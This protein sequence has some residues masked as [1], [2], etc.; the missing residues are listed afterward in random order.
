M[1]LP[2]MNGSVSWTPTA[3]QIDGLP[4]AQWGWAPVLK[5]ENAIELYDMLDP[6][7]PTPEPED[8]S[9]EVQLMWDESALYLLVTITDD[10]P[11]APYTGTW[12]REDTVELY[13]DLDLSGSGGDGTYDGVNDWEIGF[14]ALADP[15]GIVTGPNSVDNTAG[16]RAM[17]RLTANG[18]QLEAALPWDTLGLEGSPSAGMEIGLDVHVVDNDNQLG[19]REHKLA[20]HGTVDEAWRDTRRL[21][22]VVMIDVVPD[23]V[24]DPVPDPL[25]SGGLSV[26]FERLARIPNSPATGNAPRLNMLKEVPDGSGRL[27]VIDQLGYLYVVLPDNSVE[28]YLNFREELSDNFIYDGGQTGSTSFAFHPEF[29]ANGKFYVVTSVERSTGDPDFVAKRPID[30]TLDGSDPRSPGFHDILLELTAAD[31]SAS[32]FS[33][34]HREILRVEQPYGDHNLGEVA[35]N[36]NAAPGD[37]DYGL[38]YL[39]VADGGNR[40]PIDDADPENNGQDYSTIL[41][42]IIRIDP[43]GTNGR[44]GQY[45]IPEDNPF[46]ASTGGPL[47]EIWSYGHRNPHRINWDTRGDKALYAYE[48]GQGTF[49]EIN[50][51][52][53]GG[54]YG[55]GNR[56]GTSLLLEA[57]E[58]SPYPVP[59]Q[60][61]EGTYQYPVFQYDHPGTLS[62]AIAGGAVYRGSRIPSLYG[63]LIFADFTTGSR[64][65]FY[66]NLLDTFDLPYASAARY[67]VLGITSES[68]SPVDIAAALLGTGGGTRTDA[69]I[70]Q[71][72]SGEVYFTNKRN[73]W[74]HRMLPGPDEHGIPWPEAFPEAIEVAPWIIEAASLGYLHYESW[75]WLYSYAIGWFWIP[76]AEATAD[77]SGLWIYVPR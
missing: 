47:P 57:D 23:A 49:E 10:A 28:L 46:A 64:G 32:A 8:L 11:Q 68:G 45:G 16:F 15:V 74:I 54:N 30:P 35:T 24:A 9:A 14:H 72:L 29:A 38:L 33:G 6:Q 44:N 2:W 26:T 75:P 66:G 27:F 69:R 73:G 61:P 22:A 31:P 53:P 12:F 34:T 7:D 42:S 41:G 76:D 48:I 19:L 5:L 77:S 1:P 21:A 18:Y 70:H 62:G 4:D 36:P 56:E 58:N 55:W 3:I 43:M 52:V 65:L 67:H 63:K 17:A 60:E 20:W 51:I 25:P 39:A 37:P 71:D 50:R 13:L 40:F 59:E